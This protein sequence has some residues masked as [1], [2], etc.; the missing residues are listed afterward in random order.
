MCTLLHRFWVFRIWQHIRTIFPPIRTKLTHVKLKVRFFFFIFLR[1]EDAC[2]E[3]PC[4]S[5]HTFVLG[6]K[7]DVPKK[8]KKYNTNVNAKTDNHRD[9]KKKKKEIVESWAKASRQLFPTSV[10]QFPSDTTVKSKE[11]YLCLSPPTTWTHLKLPISSA[12]SSS[13]LLSYAFR[14]RPSRPAPPLPVWWW[15]SKADRRG[16]RAFGSTGGMEGWKSESWDI[17]IYIC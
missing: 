3:K 2:V 5:M 8:K 15:C 6:F 11:S 9:E 12:A 7:E 14:L 17:Y 10:K 1:Q 13:S 4:L 16:D